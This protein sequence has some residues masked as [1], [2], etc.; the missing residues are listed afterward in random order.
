MRQIHVAALDS[1]L[2]PTDFGKNSGGWKARR[3]PGPR[4]HPDLSG[5]W[6]VSVAQSRW[7]CRVRLEDEESQQSRARGEGGVLFAP[8]A[9][10]EVRS[11]LY[12]PAF[13]RYA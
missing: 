7:Q 13:G 5:A 8:R 2:A 6:I 1:R 12:P 9:S 4:S 3:W 10:F 11:Q